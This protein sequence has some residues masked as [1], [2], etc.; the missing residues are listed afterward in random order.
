M[1]KE[2]GW[3]ILVLGIF[4]CNSPVAD[5]LFAQGEVSFPAR[6]DFQV[7]RYPVSIAVGDFNGDD[8]LDLAVANF[9]SN[10]VSILLGR[11]DGTFRPARNFGVGGMPQSVTVGDFNGDALPDL[12]VAN[13]YPADVSI[14]LGNGDG[15]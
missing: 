8:I 5:S 11:G 10:D 14:L 7:G 9:Y 6:R 4:L 12:A 3:V 1:F 15:T 13:L 2:R